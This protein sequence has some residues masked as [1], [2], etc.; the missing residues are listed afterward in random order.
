MRRPATAPMPR[1]TDFLRG[2]APF[3]EFVTRAT[4]DASTVAG[5]GSARLTAPSFVTPSYRCHREHRPWREGPVLVVAPNQDAAA[6]LEHELALYCPERPVVYLPPRGVW[7]GSEGEVQPR[8][9]GRRARAVAR[10]PGGGAGGRPFRPHRGGRGGHPDGGGDRAAGSAAAV[11]AGSRHDFEGLIRALV[12]LGY[13]PRGP[14]GGRGRLLRAGRAHR[15]VPATERYPVRM[16]FWGDEVESL[17][18]FSVYSQR[19][20]GPLESVRLH[21][22][23]EER[24]T[25]LSICSRFFPG[26]AG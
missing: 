24:S 17:R 22:A 9:A 23:A 13:V 7:Y 26:D 8:V 2:Y 10:W 11:A 16:E 3:E 14:G 15:R 25:R 21:A 1:L 20:L 19:S 12:A 18:S 6:E 5:R 4:G